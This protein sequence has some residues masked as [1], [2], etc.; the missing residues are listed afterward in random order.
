M[1][2]I[3]ELTKVFK[4]GKVAFEDISF[5]VGPGDIV[6]ILGPSGCGKSTLLRVIAGLEQAESGVVSFYGQQAGSQIQDAVGVIF[7][8]PRLMP[9]LTVL[10]NVSFGLQASRKTRHQEASAILEKVGLRG[11]ELFYPRQL[12]GGMAQRVAIARALVASPDIL[13]LDEPFS[14]LDAFTRMQLQ[15]LLLEIWA[16]NR[17]TL[18]LVTHDIDEAL[19]LC[20][21]IVVMQG[22]PGRVA[23]VVTLPADRLHTRD[24]ESLADVKKSIFNI[25]KLQGAS[26]ASRQ[27]RTAPQSTGSSLTVSEPI[28]S[29]TTS[30]GM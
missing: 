2:E 24:L 29:N 28:P 9:W 3:R 27:S 16:E 14:A 1:L 23:E 30:G 19:Y 18:L 26:L 22:Q 21:T 10:D 25:L 7:Q 4:N 11:Y 5:R 8:E 17:C 13:L 15:D 12:S 20:N 6:G